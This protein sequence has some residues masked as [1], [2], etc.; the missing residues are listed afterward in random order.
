MTYKRNNGT[1]CC[2]LSRMKQCFDKL[3]DMS[4]FGIHSVIIIWYRIMLKTQNRNSN[5]RYF[6]TISDMKDC[7]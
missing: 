4:V 1:L 5:L 2:E 7:V 6:S 3:V